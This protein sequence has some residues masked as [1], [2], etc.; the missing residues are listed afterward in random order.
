MFHNF[1]GKK[2]KNKAIYAF[3]FALIIA[4]GIIASPPTAQSSVTRVVNFYELGL[5]AGTTWSIIVGGE[6]SQ[7]SG[8][9]IVVQTDANAISY[10]V[11][12]VPG[13]WSSPSSGIAT[14]N[15]SSSVNIAFMPRAQPT[16]TPTENNSTP[17]T[18][19]SSNSNPVLTNPAPSSSPNSTIPTLPVPNNGSGAT[20]NLKLNGNITTSQ[21]IGI[22]I[23]SNQ[24][25]TQTAI[26]FTVTGQSGTVG[27]SNITIPKSAVPYGVTPLIYI[28]N[29]PAANQGYTQDTSNFYVW[30]TTHFSTHQISILF[31]GS[32][33]PTE[34][35]IDTKATPQNVIYGVIIAVV[36][37][38]VVA[39]AFLAAFKR[40]KKKA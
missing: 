23:N 32:D 37:L 34:K 8:T 13:F 22:T 29:Q 7:S 11:G 28:D 26:S 35:P 31:T 40:K 24:T 16:P 5:P 18:P 6:T 27:F 17:T 30:F 39:S 36:I 1:L 15:E 4:L 14:V 2:N 21:I 33:N 25:A 12:D 20:V 9:I 3:T 10:T 19:N 38:A